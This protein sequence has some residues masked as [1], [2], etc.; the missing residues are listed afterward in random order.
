[1]KIILNNVTPAA[2]KVEDLTQSEVW[3]SDLEL[4]NNQ[5][6]FVSS[7]SGKGKSTLLNYLFG[8]RNDYTGLITMD[9][10]N[11]ADLTINDWATIRRCRLA[12]LPQDLKLIQHLSVWD[13]LLIK[14]RLTQH[15]TTDE[16]KSLIAQF[17]LTDHI[18]K[19]IHQL[20]IGQQQRI[21]LIRTILQPFELLL[22]DEPFSH[23]DDENIKIALNI[24]DNACKREGA[25]Y[26]L[27]TLGYAYGITGN[28]TLQL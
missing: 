5:S 27:A 8:L 6:Y 17:H 3:N 22:L 19:P 26:L 14:N 20:S 23:I 15:Y 16:I 28:K 21:A 2:F 24:I 25:S 11:I 10:I 7:N 9:G 4:T 18:N 1:M 12:Y 13:N